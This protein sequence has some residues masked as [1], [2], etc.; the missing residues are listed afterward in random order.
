MDG[1][2][3]DFVKERYGILCGYEFKYSVDKIKKIRE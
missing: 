2:E 1:K 3:I